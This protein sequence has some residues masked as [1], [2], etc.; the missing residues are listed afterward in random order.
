MSDSQPQ[1]FPGEKK[2][3]L[4]MDRKK[5]IKKYAL[6][7]GLLVVDMF[8]PPPPT[9]TERDRDCSNKPGI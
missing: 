4:N 2:P 9:D 1:A 6:F 8:R 7:G 3:F 5:K